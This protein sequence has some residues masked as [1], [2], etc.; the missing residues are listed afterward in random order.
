M[1]DKYIK[2]T[3]VLIVWRGRKLMMVHGIK[4][5]DTLA[6]KKWEIKNVRDWRMWVLLY[7]LSLNVIFYSQ[8]NS[9]TLNHKNTLQ[10]MCTIKLEFAKC[11][12][13]IRFWE[14]KFFNFFSISTYLDIKRQCKHVIQK[15]LLLVCCSYT[16]WCLYPC[17]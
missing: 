16:V 9:L 7:N 12:T 4:M 3:K 5:K 8:W 6:N 11:K 1:G 2:L 13:F 15:V 14:P 17:W 10:K